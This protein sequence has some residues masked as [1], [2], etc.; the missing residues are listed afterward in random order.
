MKIEIKYHSMV[1]V[2]LLDY[3]S[4]IFKIQILTFIFVIILE[5]TLNYRSIITFMKIM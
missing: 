5:D 2:I 4:K 1:K 3:Q